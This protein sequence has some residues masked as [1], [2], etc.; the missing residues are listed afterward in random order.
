MTATITTALLARRLQVFRDAG[1]LPTIPTPWQIRQG[2]IEMTLF[3]ISE[4]A[5]AEEG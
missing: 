1:L 2:E 4:D 3:V 5:T